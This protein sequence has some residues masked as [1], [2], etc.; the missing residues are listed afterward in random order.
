MNNVTSTL[1]IAVIKTSDYLFHMKT[2][3]TDPYLRR[4]LPFHEMGNIDENLDL[5]DE[6]IIKRLK[7]QSISARNLLFFSVSFSHIHRRAKK[8]TINS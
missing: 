4:Y 7:D 2:R 3:R 8:S 5:A 1:A 6:K